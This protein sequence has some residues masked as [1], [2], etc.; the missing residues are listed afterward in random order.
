LAG[1]TACAPVEIKQ[2]LEQQKPKVSI[3]GQRLTRLDFER[4][5]LAFNIQVDNPNPVGI[6]LAGLDYD[7]KLA[8]H[9]FVSGRQN[10]QMQLAAA[11]PSHFDLPLSMSFSEIYQGVAKIKGRDQVPYELTTGL[12]IDVPLLGKLRYPV[13][14]KGTLPLPKLP[15]VSLKSLSL[16][17]LTFSGATLA[18]KVAV[19]NPNAFGIDLDKLRYDFKVNGKRWISGNRRSL[20]KIQK[21]QSNVITLPISL[22]FL[23][24]GSGLYSLLNS[25]NA[26]NYN[27][28]GRLDA[29]SSHQ[30]IGSFDMPINT[31]GRISLSQ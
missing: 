9:S 23:E 27:L 25:G 3:A 15:K 21:R 20:G 7:L 2:A 30:L 22:N 11:G 28:R 16:E 26:L 5:N 19:N 10:K 18:L 8:G 1:L 24:L 14:T 17:R 4:V 12:M 6:Q 13:T 29:T 31:S